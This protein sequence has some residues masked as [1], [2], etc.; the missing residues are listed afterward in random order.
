MSKRIL[1]PVSKEYPAEYVAKCLI[2]IAS[3]ETSLG[4]DEENHPI[5]EGITNLKLQKMLFFA[6]AAYLALFDGKPLFPDEFEAWGLG[7]VIPEI[8]RKY[9]PSAD[10]QSNRP[11]IEDFECE[12]KDLRDFLED[13]WKIFGKYSASE[14]VNMSHAKGTPWQQVYS[15]LERGT[16]IP[17]K[18]IQEY[19]KDLFKQTDESE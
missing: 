13:I 11:I 14:L 17:K 4:T 7:P 18:L 5:R 10:D 12:D 19:Y 16:K 15:P 9:K 1:E 3:R 8:Y 2:G 6:Q